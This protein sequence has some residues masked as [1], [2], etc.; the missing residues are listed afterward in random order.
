MTTETTSSS[1]AETTTASPWHKD[2]VPVVSL[3]GDLM[4]RY[5]TVALRSA[6]P[7]KIDDQWYCALD[8]FP[9][10]WAKENSPKECLD[11]LEDVLREWLILKIVD[12][13]RDIPVVDEI[14]LTVASR[15]FIG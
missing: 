12:R 6:V 4:K 2:E 15:R 9:G 11:T 1:K 7:T 8:Q 5:V 13:D 10:V 3:P 14:D